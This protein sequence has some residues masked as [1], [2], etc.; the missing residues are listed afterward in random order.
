MVCGPVRFFVGEPVG[1]EDVVALLEGPV[2]MIGVLV[3]GSFCFFELSLLHFTL[4]HPFVHPSLL[5]CIL[6][7]VLHPFFLESFLTFFL[8]SF[9]EPF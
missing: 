2:L 7:Y 8:K 1:N 5:D 4:L 9:L 3:N 6:E